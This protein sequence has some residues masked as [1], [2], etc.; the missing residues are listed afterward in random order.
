MLAKALGMTQEE[1]SEIY[2]SALLHDIGKIGVRTSILNKEGK[3]TPEEYEEVKTHA[4]IGENI[5]KPIS[6]MPNIYVGAKGHH[7]HYDGSGYPEQKK[8]EEIPFLARIICVADSYDAM[9]SK[10]CYRDALP[11][12]VVRNEIVKGRGTQ[13]D[14]EVVLAFMQVKDRICAIQ[15]AIPDEEDF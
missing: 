8:G 14:P 13:F 3:L 6:I 12:E 4:K 10:R 9:T 15:L 1:I 5:L 7:E 11:Q 2:Y